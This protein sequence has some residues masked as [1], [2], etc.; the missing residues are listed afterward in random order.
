MR[1]SSGDGSPSSEGSA[2][3]SSHPVALRIAIIDDNAPI[4]L[5]LRGL[6]E[7][8]AAVKV[9]GEG[10]DGDCAA[11]VVVESA[12]D[13]AIVDYQM[14]RVDGVEATRRIRRARPSV[15]IVAFTS[16][17]DDSVAAAFVTAGASRHFD[18][19]AIEELVAYVHDLAASARR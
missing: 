12:A 2:G 6:L 16:T 1:S 18:K 19:L 3:P 9:V 14:P 4:R 13:V 11:R 5:L 17:E 8:D 7:S 15:E 10:E